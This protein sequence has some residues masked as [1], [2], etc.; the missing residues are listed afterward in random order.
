MKAELCPHS[1]W[2]LSPGHLE[3]RAAQPCVAASPCAAR[4]PAGLFSWP[5]LGCLDWTLQDCGKV[6]PELWL[7]VQ[8][9]LEEYTRKG[10]NSPTAHRALKDVLSGQ[11]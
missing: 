4:D 9:G 6:S 5:L 8:V 11:C 7:Y 1:G 3:V 2:D 10:P